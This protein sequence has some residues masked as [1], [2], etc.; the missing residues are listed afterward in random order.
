MKQK[1]LERAKEIIGRWRNEL[2][3]ID[4]SLCHHKDGRISDVILHQD[5]INLLYLFRRIQDSLSTNGEIEK[6]THA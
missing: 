5:F 1:E 6:K 4:E 3:L 2:Y